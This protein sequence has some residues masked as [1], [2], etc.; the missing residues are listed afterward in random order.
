MG[1]VLKL[2]GTEYYMFRGQLFLDFEAPD[3]SRVHSLEAE[4][5]KK[6]SKALHKCRQW[7]IDHLVDKRIR[8]EFDH[9]F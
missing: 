5:E 4:Y 7:A 1:Q 3:W 8:K 6:T 9:G 2:R